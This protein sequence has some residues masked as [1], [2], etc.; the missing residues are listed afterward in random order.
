MKLI[1]WPSKPVNRNIFTSS[2]ASFS[3]LQLSQRF[4]PRALDLCADT[5]HTRLRAAAENET[6][7]ASGKSGNS[8]NAYV[9]FRAYIRFTI[10]QDF[11]SPRGGSSVWGY[12]EP[13]TYN[14]PAFTAGGVPERNCFYL[15]AHK[16]KKKKKNI[17]LLQQIGIWGL[18]S[19]K[20]NN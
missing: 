3:F 16:K 8:L 7:R 5:S 11:I 15:G 17:H 14:S 2:S 10:K 1:L 13:S 19:W 4:S 20:K 12:D 9:I 18:C 6:R